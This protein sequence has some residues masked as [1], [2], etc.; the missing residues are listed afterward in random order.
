M[1]VA[2][3]IPFLNGVAVWR[4]LE[5]DPLLYKNAHHNSNSLDV[6]GKAALKNHA[7]NTLD[8]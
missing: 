2:K 4:I 3:V 5:H 6:A 1:P 7:R 8:Q